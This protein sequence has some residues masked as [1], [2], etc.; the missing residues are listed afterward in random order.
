MALVYVDSK[1]LV[2]IGAFEPPN[3]LWSKPGQSQTDNES[4][5]DRRNE[6]YTGNT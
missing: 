4:L 3:L 2:I 5:G 1:V 6:V